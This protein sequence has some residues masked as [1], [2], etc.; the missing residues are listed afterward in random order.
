MGITG[1]LESA[2]VVE[3]R[4]WFAGM[5]IAYILTLYH[6]RPTSSFLMIYDETWMRRSFA[7]LCSAFVRAQ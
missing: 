2:T 1:G 5:E 6:R 4:A 7:S 3:S